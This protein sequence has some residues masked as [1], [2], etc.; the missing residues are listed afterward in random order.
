VPDL[1]E[2]KGYLAT[3]TTAGPW[4][5][6][7][8]VPEAYGLNDDIRAQAD[9]LAA[10]GYLT[11]APDI[12]GGPMIRCVMRGFR[13]LNAG[14]GPTFSVIE[15]ARTWLTSRTDCTGRA[16]VIGFC[17][18]GGFALLAAAAE[19]YAAASVNYGMLPRN[20][21][22]LTGT[23]PIVASYGKRDLTLRKAAAKLESTLAAKG[24]EHD[25]KEYPNAGHSF[26]GHHPAPVIA[27]IF[28]RSGFSE[29][30]AADAWHRIEEFFAKHL[31]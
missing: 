22:A 26:L 20:D 17:L 19:D 18:G 24:V 23:C 7:V 28:T 6:V 31:R 8:V 9:H 1:E 3:P 12:L 15:S 29:P 13:E 4:P 11:F 30:D 27:R 16:G 5:A 25:V 21:E 14:H 2:P 10:S